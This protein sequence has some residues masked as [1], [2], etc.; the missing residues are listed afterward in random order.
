[1]VKILLLAAAFVVA[2]LVV[3]GI[4]FGDSLVEVD[5]DPSWFYDKWEFDGEDEYL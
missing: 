3:L 1:M 5:N 2:G 4:S